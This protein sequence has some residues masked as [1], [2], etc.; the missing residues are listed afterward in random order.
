MPHIA[1][2]SLLFAKLQYLNKE[3]CTMAAFRVLVI[4]ALLFYINFKTP[5]RETLNKKIGKIS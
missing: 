5:Y 2:F 4:N 3:S 1:C